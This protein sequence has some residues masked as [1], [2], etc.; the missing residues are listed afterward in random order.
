MV[1]VIHIYKSKDKEHL[2]NYRPISLLPSVSKI[3]E[4]VLHKE[5]YNFLMHQGIF[6]TSQY[7]FRSGHFTINAIVEFATD[8]LKGFENHEATLSVFLDL[9]K[10]FDTINHS[11]LLKKLHHYG[12]R[13]QALE[14]FRRY[15][16]DR[17]QYVTYIYD[18]C[19]VT[20]HSITVPRFE[21]ESQLSC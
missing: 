8:T 14:S 1:K 9:S 13:G 12:V 5:V 17:K 7:G 10:A 2:S 3:L 11:I 21:L 18:I 16:S 19:F 20:R 15:L 4:N 6:Y